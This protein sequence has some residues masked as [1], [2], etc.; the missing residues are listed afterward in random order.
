MTCGWAKLKLN[1][2][3]LQQTHSLQLNGGSI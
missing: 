2:F 1:K 3:K